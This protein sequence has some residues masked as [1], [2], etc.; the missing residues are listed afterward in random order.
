MPLILHDSSGFA[1]VI[2]SNQVRAQPLGDQV[3]FGLHDH[4]CGEFWL[5][6]R[7][8]DERLDAKPFV[9]D[10]LLRANLVALG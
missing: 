2:D 8:H 3:D 1:P 6:G 4:S 7:L 5:R 10:F 9:R